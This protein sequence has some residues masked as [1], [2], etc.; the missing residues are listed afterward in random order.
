MTEQRNW[1]THYFGMLKAMVRRGSIHPDGNLCPDNAPCAR[2]QP[3]LDTI[4]YNRARTPRWV[5]IIGETAGSI[6]EA[7]YSLRDRITRSGRKSL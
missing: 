6:T 1:T 7:A 4:A 3:L 5:L 2:C